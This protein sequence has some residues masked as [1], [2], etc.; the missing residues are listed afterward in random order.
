MINK[1]S[2]SRRLKSGFERNETRGLRLLSLLSN[3]YVLLQ[4]ISD[5]D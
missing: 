1:I 5:L 3:N 2:L 4:F